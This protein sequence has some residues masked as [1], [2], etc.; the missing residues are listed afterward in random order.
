MS[1]S[2]LKDLSK[3]PVS[4]VALDLLKSIRNRDGPKFSLIVSVLESEMKLY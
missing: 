2:T 4:A 1:I 3:Q